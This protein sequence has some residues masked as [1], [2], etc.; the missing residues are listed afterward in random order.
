[1]MEAVEYPAE[2]KIE[3]Q[4]RLAMASRCE[5]AAEGFR[6]QVVGPT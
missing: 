1:M 2:A 3:F 5:R 6:V 4:P